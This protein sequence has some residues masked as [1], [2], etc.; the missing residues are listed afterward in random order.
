MSKQLLCKKV[1]SLMSL[2]Q[3][4][5][6]SMDTDDVFENQTGPIP[7]LKK[8]I[9]SCPMDI[10]PNSVQCLSQRLRAIQSTSK[11]CVR[12]TDSCRLD[13]FD[14]ASDC[15]QLKNQCL[16]FQL[17]DVPIYLSNFFPVT[18]KRQ[19]RIYFECTSSTREQLSEI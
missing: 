6:I 3:S 11:L 7:S 2:N 17:I 15:P 8:G 5:L 18:K 12:I 14:R 9:G 1:S 19:T 4:D 10:K 13:S 16:K